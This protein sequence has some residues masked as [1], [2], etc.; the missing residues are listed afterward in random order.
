MGTQNTQKAR[1]L[2]TLVR[3]APDGHMLHALVPVDRIEK[4]AHVLC[5]LSFNSLFIV[6]CIIYTYKVRMQLNF[7]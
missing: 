4:L 1:E 5:L 3:H 7:I 6:V 2:H